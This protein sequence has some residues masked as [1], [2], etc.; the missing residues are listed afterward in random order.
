[1]YVGSHSSSSVTQSNVS[2]GEELFVLTKIRFGPRCLDSFLFNHI[3]DSP[4]ARTR[5]FALVVLEASLLRSG[6]YS[7]N[8]P[9]F[10]PRT[11]EPCAENFC[12]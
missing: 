6:I 7:S 8:D 4:I 2:G 3:Q 1:M 11:D 5:S 12:Y 9:N 10:I